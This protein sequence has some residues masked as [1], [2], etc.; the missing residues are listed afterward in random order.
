ML[1]KTKAA[2]TVAADRMLS[3]VKLYQMAPVLY[4]KQNDRELAYKS[5]KELFRRCRQQIDAE[6]VRL[7]SLDHAERLKQVKEAEKHL[8]E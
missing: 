3:E 7:T 5:T 2:I 8:A 4:P 1:P 6:R